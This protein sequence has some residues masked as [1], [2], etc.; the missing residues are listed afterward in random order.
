MAQFDLIVIGSGPGGYIAAIRAAQLGLNTA[1]VERDPLLGGT[2]LHRGCIPAKTWLETAHRFEQMKVADDYG[3]D[4]V[5]DQGPEGQPGGHRQA[6]GPHRPEERQGHRVP[7]EE[8]QGDRA[9][10]VRP[11]V[12][13]RQGGGG[14]RGPRGQAHH[15]GHGLGAQGDSRP[16]D[17]RAAGAQQRPHPGHHRAAGAPGDPG[18]R[19]PSAWSSPR[20]SAAWVP[21]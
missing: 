10:G 11:A 9:E 4:G 5:D 6:Q 8:E 21:R 12:G 15:P 3:I 18:R 16:G 1:I 20:C 2:C 19:A 14:G 13:R 7:H 17:R